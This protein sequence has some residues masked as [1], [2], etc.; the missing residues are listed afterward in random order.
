MV[1]VAVG[2][3]LRLI[4]R[5]WLSFGSGLREG[6]YGLRCMPSSV[7]LVR[8]VI[9]V[10]GFLGGGGRRGGKR[11]RFCFCDCDGFGVFVVAWIG[12]ESAC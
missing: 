1:L 5:L 11:V 4:W 3:D 2:S 12:R 6:G 7:C 8:L 9:K 10:W